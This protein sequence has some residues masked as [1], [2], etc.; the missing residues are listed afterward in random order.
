MV[1]QR[2]ACLVFDGDCG[3]CS[4]LAGF[5]QRHLRRREQDYV[6]VA[7]QQADL[8]ALGLTP[9][10]CQAALQWVSTQRR[11]HSGAAAVAHLLRSSRWYYRP[12]GWLISLPLLRTAAAWVYRQVAANRHWLGTQP[13]CGVPEQPHLT[14]EDQ[15][16]LGREPRS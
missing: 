2:Q 14:V 4:R 10:Q 16:R 15:P 8:A 12:L 13:T 11:I 5:T 6:V 3:M 9:Q 7:W 1:R